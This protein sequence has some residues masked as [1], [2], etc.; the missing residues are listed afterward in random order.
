M[1]QP[2]VG[3]RWVVSMKGKEVRARLTARGF[4]EEEDVP[5][6]SPTVSKKSFRSLLAVCASKEFEVKTTD[7][8]SPFLQT[9]ELTREVFLQPP[10][11]AK[12]SRAR[13]G[14]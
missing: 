12:T 14:S 3:T 2:R 5:R 4:E 9:D 6:N 8:K 11:E 7:I 10:K 1:G 13:S